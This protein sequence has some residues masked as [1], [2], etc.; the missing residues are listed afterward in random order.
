MPTL[1]ARAAAALIVASTGAAIVCSG[2]RA[3]EAAAATPS[4]EQQPL[5]CPQCTMATPR[6]LRAPHPPVAGAPD[7][8]GRADPDH[9]GSRRTDP[10]RHEPADARRYYSDHNDPVLAAL[11][12]EALARNPQVRAAAFRHQ[13][14]W[15]RLPQ[16]TALPDPTFAL[17]QYAIAP[18]TRVGPQ[19]TMVSISQ[20]LPWFGTR[21]SQ[22][23]I[24]A[25]R[26]EAEGQS[27]QMRRVEV[28]LQVKLAY[29]ELGY[30]D[31][32]L[33]ITEEE[34]QL[35]R[36]YETL[37]R[38][39]YSQGVGL[40]QAAVRLQAEITRVLNRREELL[41]QRVDAEAMLNA[42]RMRPVD[43][44]IPTV[45]LGDRP[46]VRLDSDALRATGRADRPEVR[47]AEF[48]IRSEE[49]SVRLARLGYWPDVVVGAAW[50]N[51]TTRRDDPGQANPPL[52]NGTNVF[53]I[54]VG[55]S[56]PVFRS[57]HD[58]RVREASERLS[59][60]REVHRHLLNDTELAIRSIGFRLA[61]I[62]R[63]ISLFESALLPQAA[64]AL[65]STEEAYSTGT[66]GVLDL[67]DSESVLLGVRLGLAR[68]ETDYMKALAE[69][70]RTIGSSLP[71]ERP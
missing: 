38:A 69:M 45:E 62:D 34:E 19:T 67:L 8:S 21:S 27:L 14:A 64:Q 30:V 5:V 25:A 46:D 11:I 35:L 37:A 50:T 56:I 51:V 57:K 60:A 26:A 10:H 6:P 1:H 53:G 24:A 7:G 13:A 15:S 28:V 49:G 42:L 41:R 61:T 48:G 68:L 47:A 71:E 52:G 55:A 2:I 44:P 16:A 33:R 39:Q 32:A 18:E 4:R 63:Q 40:Q 43:V 70:E 23:E 12:E 31:Q 66:T 9:H 54:T 59:A 22:G 20:R 36:H 3:G 17:T 65:R 58:A 29:Y